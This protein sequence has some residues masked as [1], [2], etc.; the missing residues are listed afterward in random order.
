MM[1]VFGLIGWLMSKL[2][3]PTVLL[4]IGFILAPILERSARQT[5]ILIDASDGWLAFVLSRPV[6]MILLGVLGLLTALVIRQR[7]SMR[8]STAP[9]ATEDLA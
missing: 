7:I 6:L 2:R 3:F 5:L 8:N 4:L 9:D 1:F